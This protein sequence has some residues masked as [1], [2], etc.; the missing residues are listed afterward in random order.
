MDILIFVHEV[1]P[2][3]AYAFDLVFKQILKTPYRI[4]ADKDDYFQ[5]TGP[6]FVYRKTPLDRGL[7]FYS[8]D[9]LFEKGIKFQNLHVENKDRL[10]VFFVNDGY[11]C[12][13]FDPFAAAFYLVTRYEEYAI[14][15]RDRHNR[16][17]HNYSIAKRNNFLQVP[18]VN[19][20]A[21]LVKEKI[22][23][24]FPD[25]HFTELKYTFQP[26]LD[27]DNA[28]AYKHKSLIR[29]T[30]TIGGSLLRFKFKDFQRKMNIFFGKEQDPYDTYDKQIEIHD[31]YR[32]KPIYFFLLG[33]R[34]KFDRNLPYT[35]PALQ[36]V[37][38]KIAER[39][40]VGMHPSY[41]S[42]R[43][44]ALFVKEKG[45]IEDLIQKKVTKSR[46][47]FLKLKFPE[48]Y[49]NLIEQGI[50]EDFSMGYSKDIGFRAGICTPFYFYD[51][52]NEKTTDLLVHSFCVMDSTLKFYLKVRS[53]EVGYTVK[54]L[55]EHIKNV[56]GEAV[57]VFHNESFGTHKIWKNWGDV[58]ETL[59]K[60][61]IPR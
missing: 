50:K 6:K 48:T 57:F 53:S 22:V 52:V 13:S 21:Q 9:L 12:L 33:D 25:A 26:T 24:I 2:R 18:V 31:K 15:N 37:V 4:T 3:I 30:P 19:Y 41:M 1:G 34:S 28:F 47:H 42:N 44:K 60:M 55:L 20:Y 7:F 11:G 59:V 29:V 40:E 56:K 54:P 5:Y 35:S 8:A 27:I 32:L 17:D 23:E 39:H 38:H 43:R 51:L 16:F 14:K 58:Y 45:R 36:A 49:Q 61:A 46:Q 10:K